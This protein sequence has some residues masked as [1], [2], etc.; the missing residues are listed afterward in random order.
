MGGGHKETLFDT[1]T[2]RAQPF[3]DAYLNK[4]SKV[5]VFATLSSTTDKT[6]LFISEKKKRLTGGRA[7]INPHYY[8]LFNCDPLTQNYSA[9]RMDY[10]CSTYMLCLQPKE[11][12]YIE[13]TGFVM[14]FLASVGGFQGFKDFFGTAQDNNSGMQQRSLAVIV[15]PSSYEMAYY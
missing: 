12:V 3:P 4:K 5:K 9:H 8:T 6:Q 10:Q 1:P 11:L 7:K 14:D 2:E 13:I 15:K